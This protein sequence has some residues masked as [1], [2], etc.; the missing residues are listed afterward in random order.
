MEIIRF[1]IKLLHLSITKKFM[2]LYGFTYFLL[3]ISVTKIVDFY[4]KK[5][6]VRFSLNF[7]INFVGLLCL[8]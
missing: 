4:I 3:W 1:Y 5:T 8:F 7:R 2:N 6:I